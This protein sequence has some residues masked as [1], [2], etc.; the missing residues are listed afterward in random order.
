MATFSIF[1]HRSDVRSVWSAS[2]VHILVAKRLLVKSK[3]IHLFLNLQSQSLVC[4]LPWSKY[5]AKLNS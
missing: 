1:K 5:D 2:F 3:F 4:E